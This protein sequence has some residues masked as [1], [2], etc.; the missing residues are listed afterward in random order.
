MSPPGGD[1]DLRG[2]ACSGSAGFG[3]GWTARRYAVL[4]QGSTGAAA[5]AAR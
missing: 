4:R 2:L 3:D 5:S 1:G